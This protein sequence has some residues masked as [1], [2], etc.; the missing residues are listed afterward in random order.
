MFY[1]PSI[2]RALTLV[3]LLICSLAAGM[4]AAPVVDTDG[5]GT[6]DAKEMAAGTD[7]KV[8]DLVSIASSLGEG[9]DSRLKGKKASERTMNVFSKKDHIARK[10]TRNPDLWCADLVGQLTGCAAW[11]PPL[12]YAGERYGGVMITSRHILFC[13]HSHPA[14]DGGWMKVQPQVIRFVKIDGTAVDMKLIANVDSP[15][16]DLSVGLLDADVPAG[17]HVVPVMPPFSP[18]QNQ[19]LQA[20]KVPDIGISQAGNRS[21]GEK[22]ESM[23]YVGSSMPDKATLRGPWQ[24]LVYPGDSGTPRFYITTKGL[25]LYVLTG[26]ASVSDNFEAIKSLIAACDASA[27]ARGVLAK[28]TGK[29]PV[30][31]KIPV[32]KE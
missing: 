25:A 4:A 6:D 8:P 30:L 26:A 5:D 9:V 10:Y 15:G 18:A 19:R 16:L 11:K 20:L 27:V 28:P 21:P 32:P 1:Q 22:N 13:R 23:V 24:Y 14:W 2:F 12:E 17:I 29:L 3:P 31:V 7:P